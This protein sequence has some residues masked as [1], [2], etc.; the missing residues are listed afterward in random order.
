M[1]DASKVQ[2]WIAALLVTVA[3]VSLWLF[4]SAGDSDLV[5]VQHVS[6]ADT[7][8]QTG[9]LEIQFDRDVID[10]EYQSAAINPP[11]ITFDP[12]IVGIWTAPTADTLL[13]EP[14]ERPAPGHVYAISLE[15]E[16]PLLRAFDVDTEPLIDLAVRPLKVKDVQ[17]RSA[18]P[19]PAEDG[20]ALRQVTID[21]TFN[22]PVHSANCAQHV[23]FEI[24]GEAQQ[25]FWTT[26]GVQQVH[27]CTIDAPSGSRIHVSVS[28][29]LTGHGGTLALGKHHQARVDV[30]I[31]LMPLR[32]Y[33]GEFRRQPDQARVGIK[34][35]QQLDPDQSVPSVTVTPDIG[36]T[37]VR[38]SGGWMY[39]GGAFKQ[40]RSYS[41]SLNP[42]LLSTSGDVLP[43]PVKLTATIAP[44]RPQLQ[45]ARR[46]GRLGT[47]GA[48][49]LDLQHVGINR[50]TITIHRLLPRHLPTYL[51]GVMRDDQVPQLGELVTQTEI[52]L[53]ES[54]LDPDASAA[55]LSLD[56]L[57][58]RIPGVY[59]IR[60][61]DTRTRWRG[62]QLLLLV[63]DS[64]INLQTH[65]GGMLAWVTDNSTGQGIQ[66]ARVRVYSPNR[67]D[68][69]E[70]MTD[71]HGIARLNTKSDEAG[72]VTAV[73]GDDLIFIEPSKA[74]AIEDRALSGA[75]WQ[76]PLDVALYADRGVHRPGEPV[77]LTGVVRTRA[78]DMPGA[79]PLEVRFTRP[80]N[81]LI[82][83]QVVM[84]DPLQSVLHIDLPTQNDDMT[85]NWR[86]S[87]HLAGDD[88]PLASLTCP[89]MP[90]LPVRLTVDATP[91]GQDGEIRLVDIASSYLHGAPAAGLPASVKATFT[92][93]RHTHDRWPDFRFE[94]PPNIA[95]QKKLV[96]GT[97]NAQ[98]TTQLTVTSPKQAGSWRTE[99]EASVLELGG[100]AT[101]RWTRMD[102]D[103]A[104]AHLGIRLPGGKLHRP[105]DQ[106]E[107][108]AIV[109]D[110]AGEP[111]IEGS[112]TAE[113]HQIENEWQLVEN[114]RGHRS[115]RSVEIATP[116]QNADIALR[117][118]LDR[119]KATVG[120][121]TAGAYRLTLNRPE[122]ALTAT[123]PL[124]VADSAASGRLS[125]LRPDRLELVPEHEQVVPGMETSILLRSPF[126]G[127]A[128]VTIETDAIVSS[129]LHP[130]E[131]DGGRIPLTIPEGVRDT[132]FVGATLIRPLDH[133]RESWLPLRAR[134]ATRL[135]VDRSGHILEATITSI[136]R[137]KPG[138]VIEVEV[139]IPPEEITGS[140]PPQV[141]LWAV[142]EGVLLL[143]DYTVPDLSGLFFQDRRRVVE[144]ASTMGDLLPDYA[145]PETTDR[146]GADIGRRF[147][148]PV[149]LRH[150]DIEVLWH[151]VRTLEDDGT[152]QFDLQMPDLDG[153]MRIMAVVIDADQFGRAEHLV[154]VTSPLSITAALPRAAAPGDAMTIPLTVHNRT[155][156]PI[157]VDLALNC[158][159]LLN[160]GVTPDQV[161]VPPHGQAMA[162]MKLNA[163]AIGRG[164]VR[165]DGRTDSGLSAQ[166]NH[167]LTVR[168]PHGRDRE[169]R[170]LVVDPGQ[171]IEIER[172]RD[173]DELNGHVEMLIGG[174]PGVDLAPVLDG[175]I[176]YPWGCAEQTGSQVQG[177]LAAS[178]LP[179][180]ITGHDRATIQHFARSGLDRLWQMQR[181]DG[182]MPYWSGEGSD[183]W[184][185]HRTA[186]LA[187]ESRSQDVGPPDR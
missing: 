91:H 152:L 24:R 129:S 133:A 145:R 141:H 64:S 180:T 13:F 48:F 27:T 52:S 54:G 16:H 23:R 22:Q 3:N 81:K 66:G 100:R 103:T 137:A 187:L 57:I 58:D 56:G 6:T 25:T 17:L 55:A 49:E 30:P 59:H 34:F 127:L 87:I 60:I 35:S 181:A 109:I 108:E 98:G 43:A 105:D 163:G 186:L 172:R 101:T 158:D 132:C 121:L 42:P 173:L 19:L 89:I 102:T 21:I 123:L 136:D 62:D 79:L 139:T 82:L 32:V 86:A 33:T 135:R 14:A 41:L 4:L 119:W 171:T 166:L 12:P 61:N 68:L 151:V 40:G 50:A 122:H 44:P 106:I 161:Q 112:I 97:L 146:I 71:E 73:S 7:F 124:H 88:E 114:K 130:I 116:V 142:E 111:T 115:W 36:P 10:P 83:E 167:D 46:I 131:G 178:R 5:R 93:Q 183:A 174:I 28:P 185:T 140:A 118:D 92:P 147:R 80:D 37:T 75:P 38:I 153:A 120:P 176:G 179:A 170:Y 69:E 29:D 51:S 165:L 155:A 8:D 45:F 134:G 148:S 74:T 26:T 125:A 39:V 77:H 104:T 162:T 99:L 84:T 53:P 182:G 20:T 15:A 96:K 18:D 85:G 47:R 90:V 149:P 128:L 113:L 138:D 76:G 144:A 157:T 175:L 143:T 156:D 164:S 117:T 177:L 31:G 67:R 1:H 70:V 63:G 94:D 2:F 126:A 11:P 72:L 107:F 65:A 159:G 168:P 95:A 110:R 150:R 154:A 160:G 9:R 78:G 169:T 184:L